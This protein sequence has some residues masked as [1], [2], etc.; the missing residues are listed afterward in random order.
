MLLHRLVRTAIMTATLAV[1]WAYGQGAYAQEAPSDD[2]GARA[3]TQNEPGVRS[4]SAVPGQLSDQPAS[5]QQSTAQTTSDQPASEQRT[6]S[7]TTSDQAAS[8]LPNPLQDARDRIYYPDDTERFRPLAIKLGGNILLDQKGI[9]TS[10]FHMHARDSKWW[11]LF[12]AATVALV[13]T[14]HKTQNIFENSIGQVTW[15]NNISKVGASYTLIPLIAGFYGYGVLRDDPK[16]REVGVLGTEAMLDS[17][18]VSEVL[19][20]IARRNRPNSGTDQ[21]HFFDSGAS[22]PS[23]HAIEAWTLASV[24]SYEYGRTKWVP[25]V[26]IGLATVVST[27]R[28]AAQ[29]HYASDI[30]VGAGMGWFIGRYVYRTHMDHAIHRHGIQ[31]ARIVPLVTPGSRTYAATVAFDF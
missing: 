30:V 2:H 15:G 16:A 17:L 28:F 27:A 18:I 31:S 13:A 7:Q 9:W 10:P 8:D 20:P 21:G 11:I 1:P 12:G 5:Q 26:A 22:F 6:S 25:A 3:A 29:Q 14:D 24:L 23:G 19:K 4:D